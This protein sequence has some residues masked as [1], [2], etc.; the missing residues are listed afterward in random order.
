MLDFFNISE[1]LSVLD[2]KALSNT[3]EGFQKSASSTEHNPLKVRKPFIN[4][5]VS[6]HN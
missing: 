3:K 2:E 5:K 1:K 4:D 6:E